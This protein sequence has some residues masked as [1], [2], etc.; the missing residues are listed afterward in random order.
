MKSR[1]RENRNMASPLKAVVP[2]KKKP[3]KELAQAEREWARQAR[4]LAI[5][6]LS[7]GMIHE[8]KNPLQVIRGILEMLEFNKKSGIY[9]DYT[10]EQYEGLIADAL[11]RV[12]DAANRAD[13]LIDRLSRALQENNNA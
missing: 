12:L 5:G 11:S 8:I 1:V 9:Q 6:K 10:L 13:G 2:G 3:G 7:A 4:N